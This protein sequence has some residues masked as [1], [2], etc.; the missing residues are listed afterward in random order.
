[1]SVPSEIEDLIAGAALSAHLATT[2]DDRPHVAP[3]WYGYDDGVLS[4]LTGGRKL[5]NCRENPRV[6]LSI[7]KLRAG[8]PIWMVAMQGVAEVS[9]DSARIEAA[10]EWI[11]PKYRAHETDGGENESG[12][13]NSE[14]ALIE[15][16]IGSATLQRYRQDPSPAGGL[17]GSVPIPYFDTGVRTQIE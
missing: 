6:A 13:E 7:E 12:S 10:R 9:E 3:V 17:P 1:M 16:T 2:T 8:D 4:A 15:I 11:F 14:S 5:A